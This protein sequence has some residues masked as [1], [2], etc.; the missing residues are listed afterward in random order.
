M[1]SY[2][3]YNPNNFSII[4]ENF[5][6]IPFGH[7]CTSAIA[8]KNAGIRKF[9]LPFDWTAPSMP[10]R[11]QKVLENNFDEF[12]PDVHNNIFRNKYNIF[13][14]HFNKNIDDGL[15]EYKRRIDRF[16][17]IM[18]E[19]GKKIYF[20]FINEDYL[21]NDNLRKKTSDDD[22]FTK[23][24]D[25]EKFLKKKYI[26]L[27]FNILYFNFNKHEI[28]SDSNI[29]NIVLNSKIFYNE[30]NDAPFNDFRKF[31]GKIL[32]ELFNINI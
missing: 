14:A 18:R 15:E 17:E 9:S 22:I 32:S 29:I 16:N 24:L 26:H 31:C 4:N 1:F 25:L 6:A 7:R 5:Y 28:P 27:D 10:D 30:H 11:I 3:I 2:E 19:K 23:M 8:C 20:I 21:Y 12:I 13:L